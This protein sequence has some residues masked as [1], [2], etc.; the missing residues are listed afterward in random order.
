MR[1][2]TATE[3]ARG[4]SALLTA[5]EQSGEVFVVTRGGRAVARIEP[6]TGTTGSAVKA[7]LVH[8]DRDPD[9]ADDLA[10][11]RALLTAEEREWPG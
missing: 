5:V 8:F 3:A 7:L 9:W 10:A 4:F 11:V 6:A 2:V 1:E